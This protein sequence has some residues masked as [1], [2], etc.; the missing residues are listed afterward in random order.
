M[1]NL[2]T[3]S[4]EVWFGCVDHFR[5]IDSMW[6]QVTLKFV[7]RFVLSQHQETMM[8][9]PVMPIS[10]QSVLDYVFLSISKGTVQSVAGGF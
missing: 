10:N 7:M 4:Q 1:C 9:H 5:V 6:T 2:K 8:K 3:A